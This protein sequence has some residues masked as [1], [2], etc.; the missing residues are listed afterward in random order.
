MHE[1]GPRAFLEAGQQPAT[2]AHLKEV[3]LHLRPPHAL[4]ED[5]YFAS[6]EPEARR[7]GGLFGALVEQLH[8]DTYAE[9]G[10]P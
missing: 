9:E 8:P 7:P 3:P 2:G 10:F 4:R 1:I 5:G 6:E